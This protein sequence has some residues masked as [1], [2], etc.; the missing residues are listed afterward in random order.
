MCGILIGDVWTTRK[1]TLLRVCL[2]YIVGMIVDRVYDYTVT[3]VLCHKSSI[4]VSRFVHLCVTN[5]PLSGM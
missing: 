1:D 5:R 2:D 3:V 4:C